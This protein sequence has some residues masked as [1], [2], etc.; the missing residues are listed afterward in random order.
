V[1]DALTRPARRTDI[2][3]ASAAIASSRSRGSGGIE[4]G[5]IVGG[6][7][8]RERTAA[9]EPLLERGLELARIE[10]AL[11][12]ART[13]SGRFLVIEGPA[14]I[15]KTALLTATRRVAA[16]GGMRVLRSR[17]TELERDFAF[18]V[19]R[20]LFEA[21][22]AEAS[23][24]E[25][26]DLLQAGAGVAARLLAFPGAPPAEA[27]L[28]SG[29]DPSFAILHGLY[30]LCANL[31]GAGPL[32]VI[33]D[34][35]HW[36][37]APSLR[38][39]AFLLTRLEELDIALV[40]ATRPREA[41][42]DAE[43]LATMT[44]DPSAE[45]I[46]L[47][48]LTS[49]AVAQLVESR[50]GRV[51]DPVFVEACLAATRGMPFLMRELVEAL[52]EGG[53]APTAEAARHVEGIGAH[54]V[55]R[56]IRLRL[57][58]LPKHAGL[59]ARAV[60][61]LEQTD[62]LQAS[63]LAGL[64][65]AEAA[66]AAELL[67]TAGILKSGRPL[68][69]IHP[70][71]RSGLYSD[72][73]SAERAGGHRRAARLLAEQPGATGRVA[74]HLLISEPTADAWVVER[75]VE[76]AHAATR[77]GAPE[78]AAVFLRRA[79]DEPPPPADQSGL[80][81]ELGMAEASAGLA[82][83]QEHLQLA[84]DAA[85][86]PAAA[87]GAA[88]VLARALSQS[89]R[90]EE[91]IEV[92]DRA[93][94]ALDPGHAELALQLEAAAVV[95]GM[96]DPA[97][98][99]AVAARRTALRKRVAGDHA[100]SPEL[101]A[102]GSFISVL[103]NEPAEIGAELATRALLAG[104][105]TPRDLKGGA[106]F[107]SATFARATLSL[108]WAERYAEVRPLLDASIAQA[109]VTGDSGRLAVGL[110]GRGW[111]A[112]RRGDLCAAEVDTRTALAATELPAPP[113]Y[114]VLNGGLLVKA[115]VDQGELDAAEQEL[116]PLESEAEG[117]FVTTAVLRLARGRLKVE[118]GR[119]AEGLEDFL[120]AGVG[121][122]RAMVTS[123]SYLPWRSEA[124][125]A[126]LALG[127][128]E[129]AGRLAQE[130]LELARTFGAPRALGVA[131]RAAGVVAGGERGELL[132]REAI[133]AFESGDARLE[134]ARALADL[135][136]MLRRRNRRTEARELLREALDAAHRA[137]AR[138]LV[139]R[140]ETELRATG[141]RPRR[142]VLTGLD[143]LTASERR[144]AELASEGLTNREI[145]QTLFVTARTVEGHLTSIFRK[146][147]LDSR[148]ELGAVLARET[149]LSE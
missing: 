97:T 44:T 28:S 122:A 100:A 24:L 148:N 1:Q 49:A 143:S 136:A 52:S 5:H 84:V 77:N 15:G 54:T 141:A 88:R 102:V 108:L 139:E 10:A 72:L 8:A 80:L 144:I 103:T 41:G 127:D 74:N 110:A 48:P 76:A 133:A 6:L 32:C 112:L 17:G 146:L 81:L 90:Y 55:G 70:I 106:W 21:P 42:T 18:G 123:P 116:A 23:E 29:V 98:A 132:L 134:R 9:G 71:V 39:L 62:L 135:G 65:D 31:A 113:T 83:W 92:L 99:P 117:G 35:A 111:L 27:P 57:R 145:A 109:R 107:S 85:S 12:E 142:V 19:V 79:I 67:A 30:W 118:Q 126:H 115:L 43:L 69:F 87:A 45:V 125:L 78:S 22:L 131:S 33:V 53:I 95:A 20:Q 58:R 82:G 96:S 124:A 4:F 101:L 13:G 119:V 89:Q 40:L 140:A 93:S 114:R 138:S 2:S 14:G 73:T 26:G 51:P 38:Y 61:I 46:R 75:L 68:T 130:E 50:L 66:D 60:A 64:D 56:S 128:H 86:D 36:A 105:G 147:Q 63:R 25:R 34:D 16:E 149:R 129:S 121:L 59:L 137:G 47:P 7:G 11:A 104:E 91:A 37:D 3:T 120:G 94:S